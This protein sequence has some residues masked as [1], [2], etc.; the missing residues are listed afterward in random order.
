M[1]GCGGV[2]TLAF[3][4]LQAIFP[5]LHWGFG[6]EKV[7][8][9]IIFA[10]AAQV[11]ETTVSYRRTVKLAENMQLLNP[12]LTNDA[13]LT[14]ALTLVI[15][16]RRIELL[17]KEL[18]VEE[19][20]PIN[21]DDAS[22]D[23]YENAGWSQKNIE[24]FVKEPHELLLATTDAVLAS[25]TL[26]EPG[27]VARDSLMQKLE[28][29]MPFADVATRFSDDPSASV[30]GDLDYLNEAEAPQWMQTVFTE[31][32]YKPI[33]AES[34]A[35]FWILRREDE[36]LGSDGVTYVRV[37]GIAVLKRTLSDVLSE[38]ASE[39]PAKIYVW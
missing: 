29:G 20:T 32:A 1:A 7:L 8:L 21:E 34:E 11:E 5:I 15:Q 12:S 10:P 33:F 36:V 25:P 23:A 14:E 38:R 28:E 26:Q 2:I 22:L 16:Q 37:R 4:G 39:Y 24:R 17:A 19:I 35:S 31:E 3:F 6:P 30:G 18:Q 13:A 9:P 27:M